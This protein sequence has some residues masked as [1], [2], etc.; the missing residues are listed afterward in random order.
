MSKVV[1]VVNRLII[2]VLGYILSLGSGLK[3]IRVDS[4]Y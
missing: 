1:V 2:I 3:D 4:F